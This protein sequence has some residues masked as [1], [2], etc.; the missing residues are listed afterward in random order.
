[1]D[2]KNIKNKIRRGEPL[3]EPEEEQE[4]N[5][6]DTTLYTSILESPIKNKEEE[7][8]DLDTT[9]NSL[10]NSAQSLEVKSEKKKSKKKPSIFDKFKEVITPKK[11]ILQAVNKVETDQENREYIEVKNELESSA[12]TTEQANV[13]EE[14]NSAKTEE[15]TN[16]DEQESSANTTEQV[17]I[18]HKVTI[19]SMTREDDIKK[20]GEEYIK[21]GADRRTI[22]INAN[23]QN[24]AEQTTF[25]AA[26]AAKPQLL[27]EFMREITKSSRSTQGKSS[28]SKDTPVFEG[29]HKE[30]FNQWLFKVEMDI[31]TN[32]LSNK[33]AAL[34]ICM[35]LKGTP[36]YKYQTYHE[37]CKSN[38]TELS[39]IAFKDVLK[40][41]YQRNDTEFNLRRSLRALKKRNCQTLKDYDDEFLRITHAIGGMSSG[42]KIDAY[43]EG[44]EE[45][46]FREVVKNNPKT[47]EEAMRIADTFFTSIRNIEVRINY[48][49]EVNGQKP[50]NKRYRGKSKT[51]NPNLQ[52]NHHPTLVKR[53][54]KE[55]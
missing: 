17:N 13:E 55:S 53:A 29:T 22:L 11:S 2:S 19:I 27:E 46:L 10:N 54:A 1:M 8:D 4:I 18:N 42:E 50:F 41:Q 47:I 6:N 43:V 15:Q 52:H 28:L 21:D 20:A 44:L 24:L 9:I 25:I 32:G 23:L 14:E 33:Q 35:K 40:Q 36:L 37:Q 48:V 49:T 34:A 45:D 16:I 38:N 12:K 31:E 39:W 5:E 30:D 3:T 26:I 7:T 51:F